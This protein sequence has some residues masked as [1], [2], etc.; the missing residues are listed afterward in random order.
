M[1]KFS[2][3]L[4]RLK[5]GETVLAKIKIGCFQYTITEVKSVSKFEPRKGEIDLLQ[6]AIKIDSDMTPQDK[7][8]T[9]LHEI[10]HGIDEFM[11]IGLEEEQVKKLGA[12]L[13]M[14]LI[15]NPGLIDL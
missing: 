8:E 4:G 2:L 6:R 1:V 10:I 9:L 3:Y 7:Q 13:A 12:A 5:E 11:R 14:V 15:D